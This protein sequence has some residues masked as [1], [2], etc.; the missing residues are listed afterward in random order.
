M[1][2][3]EMITME[4]E[5]KLPVT[6]PAV[7]KSIVV[8]TDGSDSSLAAFQAARLIA[9]RSSATVHVVS[10]LEPLPTMLV[11]LT[12]DELRVFR[13]ALAARFKA[14]AVPTL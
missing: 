12:V 10:V 9:A 14:L 6:E 8:A 13:D 2:T 3:V 7:V 4:M 5:E 11:P 1:T